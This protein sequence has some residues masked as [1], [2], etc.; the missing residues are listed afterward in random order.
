LKHVLVI[1]VGGSNVK[2]ALWG[3]RR[4]IK[5]PS[6]NQLTAR[7]M[8]RRVL[9]QTQEWKYDKVSIGVPGSVV[10]GK[11]VASSANLG[12]GWVGFDFEKHFGKPVK[13]INDGAMQALGSYQ[14]GRML[15]IGLGTGL[16]SALILDAAIIPLELG[17]LYYSEKH[18]LGEILGKAGLKRI[19][20]AAWEKAV[21]NAVEHLAAAFRT[22]YV[23]LGGGNVKRLRRLPRGARR[24]NNENAFIGGAR[25]WGRAGMRAVAQKH[26]WIMR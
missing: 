24:G 7:S 21:H 11:I 12:G 8:V 22:D 15:F 9:A 1:D 18:T 25:L 14:G 17:N 10:H 16:G 6:G 19:G 20:R 13:V 5:I 4:K 3:T 2:L 23:M 26:T